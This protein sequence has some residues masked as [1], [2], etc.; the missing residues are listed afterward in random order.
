MP[1]A[2]PGGVPRDARN[3]THWGPKSDND[4]TGRKNIP[5]QETS[6]PVLMSGNVISMNPR[7]ARPKNAVAARVITARIAPVI[8]P[9]LRGTGGRLLIQPPTIDPVLNA[10]RNVEISHAHT[11]IDEPK[12]GFNR[13]DASS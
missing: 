3:C 8:W 10:A 11:M 13:R 5:T 9:R 1:D 2:F 4:V 7:S 12:C 6:S